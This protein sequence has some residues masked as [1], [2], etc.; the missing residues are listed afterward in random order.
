MTRTA[1]L[2]RLG[3]LALLTGV[4]TLLPAVSAQQDDVPPYNPNEKPGPPPPVPKDDDSDAPEVLGRG[5]IH[6]GF[7]QPSEAPKAGPTAPKA[8]PDPIPEQ[9]P[10]ERPEG[11]NVVWVPGYWA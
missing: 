3:V 11:D 5:P 7:A 9:P 2:R 4:F 8:P 1:I 6:E 10:E